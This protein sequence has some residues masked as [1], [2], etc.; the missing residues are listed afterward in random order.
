MSPFG[1]H[2][3]KHTPGLWFHNSKRTLFILVVDGFCVQYF[4]TED[5]DHFLNALRSKYLITVVLEATVYIGIKLTWDYLHRT[6]ILSMPSYFHKSLHIF[7][8]ILRGGKEYSPHSCALIQ[9]GQK[10][11]YADL[12]ETAEYMSDKETNLVQHVCRTF[13][14]YAI[15]IDNT[16]L[17]ALS[18]ISSEQSKSTTNTA[19]QVAKLLNCIASNPQARIQ[20]ISSGM[21]LDIHSNTSYLSV[22]QARS[23]A[24]GVHFLT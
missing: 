7:Q 14:Y 9:Y 21:K 2:P 23:W 8:N 24:S 13:L 10:I 5:A 16:I 12:L 6:F 17:P 18:N 4:S 22:A 3:V 19:K 15:A 20:Y 1:Y 11:Q